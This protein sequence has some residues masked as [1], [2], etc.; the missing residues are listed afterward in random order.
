MHQRPGTGQSSGY[1]SGISVVSEDLL[2]SAGTGDEVAADSGDET[3]SEFL[4]GYDGVLLRGGLGERTVDVDEAS[5]EA[6]FSSRSS[7]NKSEFDGKCMSVSL[8][9]ISESLVPRLFPNLHTLGNIVEEAFKNFYV[10][11]NI[12]QFV[13]P[14]GKHCCRLNI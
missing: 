5:Q 11:S 14:P 13:H 6:M 4:L 12:S 1:E 2:V 7:F 3:G 9:N 10:S 8:V